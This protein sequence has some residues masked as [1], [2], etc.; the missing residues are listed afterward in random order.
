MRIYCS[1]SRRR[2][3][4]WNQFLSSTSM[5]T[6]AKWTSMT[7]TKFKDMS[8]LSASTATRSLP[9]WS[10]PL[11]LS[12]SRTSKNL[13][14]QMSTLTTWTRFKALSVTSMLARTLPWTKTAW[15]LST[16]TR[17]TYSSS[18]STSCSFEASPSSQ[19]PML[20]LTTAATSTVTKKQVGKKLLIQRKS[21]ACYPA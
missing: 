1:K 3:K 4:W 14:W 5:A 16:C 11:A 8:L 12:G 6:R 19:S 18:K 10:R 7:P 15:R 21:S 9:T 2:S 17:A 13:N 20:T